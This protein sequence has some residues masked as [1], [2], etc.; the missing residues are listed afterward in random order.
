MEERAKGRILPGGLFICILCTAFVLQSRAGGQTE[1]PVTRV[2]VILPHEDDGYWNLVAEGI[3]EKQAEM[4]ARYNIDIS[5]IIPQLNYNIDQM[6]DILKQQIAAQVDVLVVQGTENSDFCDALLQAYEQGIKIICVDTDFN[7][8]PEHLY[9]G[10]DNYAAGRMLGESLVE[11]T[12]GNARLAIVSGEQG[13]SN[14]EQRLQGLMDVIDDYPGIEPGEVKYDRYDALTVMRLYQE[15]SDEADVMVYL[16]GTG[17][18][19][20]TSIFQKSDDTYKYI[21]G[22][23]AYEGVKTGVLDGIVKQDT[24]Q[25]GHLVVEEIANFIEKGTYSSDYIYTNVQ[26]VT[27]ENYDEVI[28]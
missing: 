17:G 25:M 7:D 18:I 14:L 8:F 1:Y 13:Y 9:I 5:M 16:E 11:L 15:L 12:G 19:T 24:Q 23:D 2:S 21:L 28:K 10:T 22:F 27:A 6:V 26:W 3:R 20:L 4:G